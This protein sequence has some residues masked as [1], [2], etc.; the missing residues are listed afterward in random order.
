M[1]QPNTG[2]P[3]MRLSSPRAWD[4][5]EWACSQNPFCISH[6]SDQAVCT[7]VGQGHLSEVFPS[8]PG[9]PESKR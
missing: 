6:V 2:S 4:T 7:G 1:P 3:F 5:G 9:A 8:V